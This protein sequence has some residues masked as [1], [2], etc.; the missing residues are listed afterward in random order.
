[1]DF[2][3]D[4][5]REII[6]SPLFNF[7]FG[8]GGILMVFVP[9]IV[10]LVKKDKTDGQSTKEKKKAV[11]I[12][13]SVIIIG[14]LIIVFLIIKSTSNNL[15]VLVNAEN[16]IPYNWSV[17]IVQLEGGYQIDKRAYD[18]LQK[19]MGDAKANGWN[20]KICSAYRTTAYQR[21]LFDGRVKRMQDQGMS[22]E[23]AIKE[24]EKIFSIPG[25]SEHET[26]LAVDIVTDENQS[27]DNSQLTSDCQIWLME[28][29]YDYGFILRYPE[30]KE[31]ITGIKFQPWH[32]RYV[33]YDAA[34]YIKQNGI[35]LEE[36]NALKTK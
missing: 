17:R 13:G 23:E 31:E 34:Q 15:D 30:D 12:S 3:I 19:M 9:I 14:I 26:G 10:E 6:N 32:Y 8:S 22:E 18:S 24:A 28:H 25:T 27:L 36:Y 29:C 35:C 4:W 21:R 16:P 2:F 1:M 5:I 7:W 33:G 11:K 20:P